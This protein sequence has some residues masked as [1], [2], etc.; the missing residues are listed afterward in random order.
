[1]YIYN[2]S[3]DSVSYRPS[4]YK[5]NYLNQHYMLLILKQQHKVV[6][7]ELKLWLRNY[8]NYVRVINC[9]LFIE[10]NLLK[11]MYQLCNR[12]L[13]SPLQKNP[14]DFCT[15][16][17]T[18]PFCPTRGSYCYSI[19]YIRTLHTWRLLYSLKNESILSNPRFVWSSNFQWE[20]WEAFWPES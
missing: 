15:L 13:P 8:L 14:V 1:M 12:L 19:L 10:W 16:S 11:K 7:E 4:C 2:F 18:C 6:V 17:S 20:L 5:T 3:L 9:I